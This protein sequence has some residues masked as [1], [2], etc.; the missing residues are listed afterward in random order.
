MAELAISVARYEVG[1]LMDATDIECLA[2]LAL[3]S[4]DTAKIRGHD[5][6]GVERPTEYGEDALLPQSFV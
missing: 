4:G 6:S 1:C 3:P 2:R 5:K